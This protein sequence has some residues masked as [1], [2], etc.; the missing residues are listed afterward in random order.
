[1]AQEFTRFEQNVDKAAGEPAREE[2]WKETSETIILENSQIKPEMVME[3]FIVK[4]TK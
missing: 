3:N 2:A 1:M 4:I